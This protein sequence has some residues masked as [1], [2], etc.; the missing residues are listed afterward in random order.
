M[1]WISRDLKWNNDK[2]FSYLHCNNNDR[3]NI[4]DNKKSLLKH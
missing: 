4:V 3:N 2:L 1:K